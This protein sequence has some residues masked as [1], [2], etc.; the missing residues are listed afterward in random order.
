[1][2]VSRKT[3]RRQLV[4]CCV[5]VAAS[6][7][8]AGGALGHAGE[9]DPPP[10]QGQPPVPGDTFDN[11][12]RLKGLELD[13]KAADLQLERERTKQLEAVLAVKERVVALEAQRRRDA[14]FELQQLQQKR[15]TLEARIEYARRTVL[16][17]FDVYERGLIPNPPPTSKRTRSGKV[18]EGFF[19]R[20]KRQRE[21]KLYRLLEFREKSGGLIA[22][23]GA[24]NFF[25]ELCGPS[26]F[27][28]DFYRTANK[29]KP[30][31]NDNF[32]NQLVNQ[33]LLQ[34][35]VLEQIRY[36]RGLTGPKLSGR[37]NQPPLDVNWPAIL[38][39]SLKKRT[40]DIER[41]REA[42]LLELKNKAGVSPETA[43]GLLDAVRD[44]L[45][46]MHGLEE[47]LMQDIRK[48]GQ[49]VRAQ[50]DWLR[51]HSAE[52]HVRLLLAG[53]YRLIEAHTL[54]DVSLPPLNDKGPATVE[55][56]LTYM[57]QNNLRFS[58]ADANGQTAYNTIFEL[59]SRYYIDLR[60]LKLDTAQ[61]EQRVEGLRAEE[62]E[63]KEVALGN[64]LDNLQQTEVDV[65]R[66]KAMAAMSNALLGAIK[67]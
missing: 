59:M 5:I 10:K 65:A 51:Y 49:N 32:L 48:N 11:R 45:T 67:D 39:R 4:V 29:G 1:M 54:A 50:S 55:Q 43:D 16:Q 22:S 23:G 37:L 15:Q 57:H 62:A 26:A 33:F 56:L 9:P 12:I 19:E 18:I 63:V 17:S 8:C 36:Q 28:H 13:Q 42:V 35:A 21:Q 34:P 6:I 60:Q 46:A 25:V 41:R 52:E 64:R 2:A 3:S 30:D 27:A 14:A 24:L 31:P 7:S 40:D 61:N 53:A 38:N 20:S 47:A 44:L 66:F 58:P